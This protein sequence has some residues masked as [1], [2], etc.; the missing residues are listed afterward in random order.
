MRR[1]AARGITMMSDA[2]E[3]TPE[4]A[5]RRTR[6]RIDE[7][8]RD[9]ISLL[10]R[11]AALSHRAASAK[12]GLGYAIRDA[13]REAAFLK[14]RRRCAERLGLDADAVEAIFLAILRFS[15]GLQA[16]DRRQPSAATVRGRAVRNRAGR[17]QKRLVVR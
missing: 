3:E 4:E 5:L 12:A 9:I 16:R 14:E 13:S 7:L 8:D 6:Q 2:L 11:R 1:D 17:G 10:S 15:R